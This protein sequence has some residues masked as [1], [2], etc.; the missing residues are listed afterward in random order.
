VLGN[1]SSKRLESGMMK[2]MRHCRGVALF[3]LALLCV[4]RLPFCAAASQAQSQPSPP[5]SAEPAKSASPKQPP[6]KSL[7]EMDELQQAINTAGNDRVA[8]VRNLEAFLTKY[9][10]SRERP[11]I[12]RA[13]VEA[14]LQLRDNARATDYAERIVAI[15]PEDISMTLL[16]I[17][18]L[19]RNG[20]DPALRRALTYS[21]RVLD[22]IDRT[23]LGPKSPKI[24]LEE[25]DAQQKHDRM[26]VLALRGQLY[27]KLHNNADAQKDFQ[28]SMAI[29]PT[30]LA[31]EKL[32]EIAEAN[33]DSNSAIK[34][35]AQAFLLS[36]SQQDGTSRRDIRQKL[37]NVWRLAHGS[38]QGL[39]D[40]LL[41]AYDDSLASARPPKPKLNADA[42]E[43]YEFKL[44]NARDGSAYS[45]ADQKGKVIVLSFWAT[46]CGPCRET[47]PYFERAAA[48]F[49]GNPDV[50]FLAADCD[51]DETLVPPYLDEVKPHTSV[52]FADGLDRLLGV[53]AYP[54]F[55][56]LDRSGKIAYRAVGA[57][58]RQLESGL[59]NAV[60]RLLSEPKEGK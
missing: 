16:A 44:R 24:S 31:A 59:G 17:Q 35:Y 2:L 40:A 30:A 6:L 11:Q 45:L 48:Q 36:S 22:Y 4:V 12:Y 26:N 54:T 39:G 52:V 42:R 32:G 56:V 14:S 34:E 37:G 5:Q 21:T 29:T 25:W 1:F 15:S 9:P 23:S 33:K 10:E 41:G 43:P 13:L 47:E 60:R 58:P 18:L 46:W 50:V 27:L 20:D 55:V 19:E 8:L 7:S 49:Q 3:L 57:D 28:A 51:E 53:T 38:D